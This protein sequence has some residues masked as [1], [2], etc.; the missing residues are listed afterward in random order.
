MVEEF[1]LS[2]KILER[3]VKELTNYFMF[4][5]IVMLIIGFCLGMLI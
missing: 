5:N 4:W 3:A 1:N 2:E